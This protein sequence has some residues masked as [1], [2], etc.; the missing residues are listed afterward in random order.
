MLIKKSAVD[1]EATVFI[2]LKEF[3]TH[4][5]GS[6][7]FSFDITD[8]L[9]DGKNE[10]LVRVWDP[11][12]SCSHPLGKQVS[13][14]GGIWYTTVTGI[15]KS[16]WLEPVEKDTHIRAIRVSPDVDKGEVEFVVD[17]VGAGDQVSFFFTS[18]RRHTI[19]TGDWSSDVC[20]SDLIQKPGV[21]QRFEY[22]TLEP[23]GDVHLL[24]RSVVKSRGD[25]KA[26]HMFGSDY[27]WQ[28]MHVASKVALRSEER[29]VGK[30]SL[31]RITMF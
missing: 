17:V 12:D 24:F 21:S 15:W 1:W 23:L 9:K 3:P 22:R 6:D 2:N 8:A 16:V 25:D 26:A 29:R 19:W 4:R 13:K 11:T 5:G 20:S 10:L 18:G 28:I 30:E 31:T 14:R 27:L 7:P